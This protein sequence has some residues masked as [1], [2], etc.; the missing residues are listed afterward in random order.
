VADLPNRS[1]YEAR[2][3]KEIARILAQNR[4][5]WEQGNDA[6]ETE[7]R[8]WLAFGLLLGLV[9]VA[10]SKTAAGEL[11]I[12]VEA[13]GASRGWSDS[14]GRIAARF[15]LRRV[16]RAVGLARGADPLGTDGILTKAVEK[17]ID[18]NTWTN[19]VAT[20]ITRANTAGGEYSAM[21]YNIGRFTRPRPLPIVGEPVTDPL[22]PGELVPPDEPVSSVIPEPAVA[23]WHASTDAEGNPDQK[24]CPV[25]RPLHGRPRDEWERV[26]PMGP[27]AHQSCR[28]FVDYQLE[29]T[30]S[31]H[32][33]EN[34]DGEKGVW[35]TIRGAKVF[36]Q[37]GRITKGPDAL[38]DKTP[39]E[40]ESDEKPK[41]KRKSAAAK[42]DKV[43]G[44]SK[45]K[46]EPKEKPKGK[47]K[48]TDTEEFKAWFG[49]S[50]VVD[51]D[52]KP[53]VVYRGG[54]A[55]DW[56]TGEI[57]RVM[58]RESEFPAFNSG[59]AGVKLA[60]FFT[61]E[62]D[63]ADRFS[64]LGAKEHPSNA[65]IFP[66]YLSIQKPFVIDAK[67]AAAGTVQFGPEGKP[68]RDAIRS[69]KYDGVLIRN[70][71]DEGNLFIA[72]KPNQIK[73]A[74]GNRGT[75]SRKSNRIDESAKVPEGMSEQ[76]NC[77]FR[78]LRQDGA[79]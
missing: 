1:E 59:E 4:A 45:E 33:A 7:R 60:G 78:Q 6:P 51:K 46:P 63:V 29:A 69:G 24:V 52:G 65:A 53:L 77:R 72:L 2:I 55:V 38:I 21:I 61:D 22:K 11:G 62:P 49:D 43:K 48:Q 57:L 75:F 5:E 20:E 19:F 76:L 68:F 58:D 42:P 27:P 13:G 34:R 70:T 17:I 54:S 47:V 9:F 23:L 79:L 16:Q 28:C 36:I 50:K 73:S 32:E 3:S 35:R 15:A 39:D 41:R 56:N 18:G 66:V 14:Y 12:A 8:L 71:K 74:T 30:E 67:G 25:C 44:D 31:V 64:K 37:N 10:G 40:A 26:A